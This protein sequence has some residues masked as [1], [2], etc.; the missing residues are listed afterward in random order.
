MPKLLL[1]PEAKIPKGSFAFVI[2]A[3]AAESELIRLLPV[4]GVFRLV[5]DVDADDLSS[6]EDAVGE[7]ADAA[8]ES[9]EM[10]GGGFKGRD[11]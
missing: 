3:F 1:D 6:D 9:S 7:P 11:G 8:E 4:A 2:L 5:I 10:D